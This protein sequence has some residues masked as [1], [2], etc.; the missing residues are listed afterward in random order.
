M[1]LD[2]NLN[3]NLDLTAVIGYSERCAVRCELF[4]VSCSKW[5]QPRVSQ[6]DDDHPV[7]K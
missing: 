6:S 7:K 5:T 2:V 1:E 3:L 4:A